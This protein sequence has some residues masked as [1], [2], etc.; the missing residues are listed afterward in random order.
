MREIKLKYKSK[1]LSIEIP[2]SWKELNA[3]QFVA[4]SKMYL[5]G[6]KTDQFIRDF[7]S[8]PEKMCKLLSNYHKYKLIE[9]V[10][11]LKD[12]RVP[13]NEFFLD[14][15]P[16]TDF[17][18]PGP[19]LDGVCFQQFMMV[20]T[21][22]YKYVQTQS[23][24]W[25]DYMIACLYIR[26]NEC[27]VLSGKDE[28]LLDLEKR[29]PQIHAVDYTIKYAIFLNFI[30]IK[31]WLGGAYIHLFPEA[32]NTTAAGNST[33]VKWLDIFDRFVGDNIPYMDK[34][35]AMA[36]TDAFRIMNRKIKEAKKNDK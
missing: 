35:Q 14:A 29:I 13:Y 5:G 10:E 33:P 12:A 4:A 21:Y 2:A 11:F 9:M 18:A 7:F 15:I 25:L 24:D 28:N 22:F 32:D 6:I 1:E 16:G 36:C 26:D 27:F 20:D 34:Y 31:R 8:I 30:L 3:E 23:I 17:Y 19:K